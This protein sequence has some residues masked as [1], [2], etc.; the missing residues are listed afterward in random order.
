MI[1][2][3]RDNLKSLLVCLLAMALLIIGSTIANSQ[4]SSIC[5]IWVSAGSGVRNGGTGTL[6]DVRHDDDGK[7]GFVL[8]CNHI[9]DGHDGGISVEFPGG[10]THAAR[11]L[12]TDETNDLAALEIA[13][14]AVPALS[15]G[16]FDPRDTFR[17]GGFGT[18]GRLRLVTGRVES[19]NWTKNVSF[20]GGVRSG[21]SGG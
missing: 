15:I 9:F 7:S 2:E 19:T 14:P 16:V 11:L 1:Q 5:R 13:N 10:K 4:E 12:G 17:F 20:R 8:T 3:Q 18:T 21:D 6:V